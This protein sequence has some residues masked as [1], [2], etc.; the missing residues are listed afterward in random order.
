MA[1][2]TARVSATVLRAAA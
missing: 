1:V 2:H